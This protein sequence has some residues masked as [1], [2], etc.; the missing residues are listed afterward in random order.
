MGSN[1][2]TYQNAN[3]TS[4][5]VKRMWPSWNLALRELPQEEKI[6][7]VWRRPLM[8]TCCVEKIFGDFTRLIFVF[9]KLIP[10]RLFTKHIFFFFGLTIVILSTYFP[11][12]IVH[13]CMHIFRFMCRLIPESNLTYVLCRTWAWMFEYECLSTTPFPLNK[14]NEMKKT[15]LPATTTSC[16]PVFEIVHN[17]ALVWHLY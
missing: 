4:C 12:N 11:C 16:I 5:S 6:L 10:V 15:I 13:A 7:H 2:Q 14:I 1:C 8:T 3:L 17:P 9:V